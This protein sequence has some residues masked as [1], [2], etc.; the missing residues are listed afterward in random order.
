VMVDDTIFD[1]ASGGDG[2]EREAVQSSSAT[3]RGQDVIEPRVRSRRSTSWRAH[4][5]CG[6]FC[7]E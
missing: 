2:T 3:D 7:S 1:E 4:F 5:Q 6:R